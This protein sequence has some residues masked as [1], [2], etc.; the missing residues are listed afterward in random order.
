MPVTPSFSGSVPVNYD[1]YLGP[2]LFEPYAEDLAHRLQKDRLE[3]VLELACGTGR[4]TRHLIPLLSASGQMLATDIN[5]DMLAMA[6]RKLSDSRLQWQV[7]DAMDLPFESGR[8]YHVVCQLGV[9]FF[10]DKPKAFREAYRVLNKGG[11][12]LFSVWDEMRHN[13]Q[14]LLIHNVI[15]DFYGE[16]APDFFKKG[17]FSFYSKEEIKRMVS[18]AGFQK[19][20]LEEVRKPGYFSTVDD[21]IKGFVD[22]SPLYSFLSDK[23]A[24]SLKA[25]QKRL[26][27]ELSLQAQQYGQQAP[28]QAILVEALK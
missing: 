4:V 20:T 8:F 23:P 19:V 24:T 2:V 6:Q 11:K 18:G 17:P 1:T 9:M 16:E 25:L 12:F 26:H 21:V 27:D 14:S 7:V 15:S 13:P 22:G 5:A 10:S 3:Q 28:L